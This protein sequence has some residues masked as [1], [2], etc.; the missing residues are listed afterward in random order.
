MSKTDDKPKKNADEPGATPAPSPAPTPAPTAAPTP[1]PTGPPAPTPPPPLDM[2]L[3]CP[4]CGTQHIDGPQPEI[5]WDDPPHRTH[6]C[7]ACEH[8]WRPADVPTRGVVAILSAGQNQGAPLARAR[9]ASGLEMHELRAKVLAARRLV[10]Q[11]A[12]LAGPGSSEAAGLALA[13]VNELALTS[14][15]PYTELPR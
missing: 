2:V 12:A 4:A 15:L 6:K 1:A 5:G 11:L 14:G 7:R 13:A 3:Y 8:E 9:P 10:Q